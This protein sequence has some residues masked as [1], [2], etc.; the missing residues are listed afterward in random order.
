[1]GEHKYAEL[2]LRLREEI[3]SGK[4]VSGQKL[5][6]ENQLSEETGYSRQTLGSISFPLFCRGLTM[7]WRGM[8]IPPC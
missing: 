2:V 3:L 4:Y 6:S 8:D 7:C 1:M 5:P